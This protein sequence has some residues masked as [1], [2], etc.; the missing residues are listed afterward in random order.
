M[1]E[2]GI[3]KLLEK[4]F[5]QDKNIYG[6]PFELLFQSYELDAVAMKLTEQFYKIVGLMS[7]DSEEATEDIL[8]NE[9]LDMAK[10]CITTIATMG[11]EAVDGETQEE[12]G[13]E[14]PEGKKRTIGFKV[15]DKESGYTDDDDPGYEVYTDAVAYQDYDADEEEYYEE[16]PDEEGWSDE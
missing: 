5:E 2:K 8:V 7:S 14:P 15:A 13:D 3:L 10:F 1:D 4:E 11:I 12:E 9:L 16:N 6:N